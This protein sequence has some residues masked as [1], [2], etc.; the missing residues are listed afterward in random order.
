MSKIVAVTACPTGVAHTFMAAEAL[1]K[2]ADTMGHELEL[3]TQGSEGAKDV[4]APDAIAQADVVIIA[5]DI[6]VDPSRFAGKAIHAVS[7]SDAIRQTKEV[8]EAA[9]AEASQYREEVPQTADGEKFIVGVTSCPTGIAHTFMAAEALKK[10][11]EELGHEVKIE[12]QG[13]VGAK[14]VLSDD[15][16]ARADAVIIAADAFVDKTRFSGK[17][18]FETSTKEALHNGANAIQAA[19]SAAPAAKG[20]AKQVDDLKSERSAQ[21]TGPYRHLMTGVSY[22]LPVVVA[23]GLLIALA[24]AF[25]GIY[26]GDN[27]GT[28]GWALMQIGGATAFKL[29]VPVLGAFIAYSI[30]ER[31]GIAPGLIGGLLATT[32]GSGF[33]GGI[34]AGF[35]AGYLTK[36]LNDKIQLPQNLQGLKP[37][38]ILPF[39]STLIVGLLMIYVIGPPVNVVLTAMT[40]WLQGMQSTSSL[41]L[42]LILGAMM[43]F[44]MG[45]PVNKAAYTFGVGLLSSQIYGPMAAIMAAGMVPPLGLALAATLFKNRFTDDE[46]E[47]S[48]A[49]FVLGIS[50]IT[51]GAIP[52]AARDPFRVIP[53]IMLGSAVTGA[54]SMVFGAALMVPHGGIFVL[55]IPNAVTQLVPYAVAILVGMLVT[56]AALFALKKPISAGNAI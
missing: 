55:F 48:K 8:I 31:P 36:F 13:S 32:V 22:M 49:A 10:A 12:T 7:T 18:L 15:E 37:V 21:R 14:N 40:D 38:L 53:C 34:V 20:L 44:D 43:A 25:G 51:E 42:G 41:V 56:A 30:A 33:L 39:L 4:L 11:A 50:F 45:G 47:A 27:E 52:F 16:I 9:F 5:A 1:K 54:L 6:H 29:F 28:L 46:Q 3:E 17:P 19:L 23:G 2:V 35:L 26:A 24:F